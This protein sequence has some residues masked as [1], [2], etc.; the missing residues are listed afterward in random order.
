MRLDGVEARI[1]SA[2]KTVA[3]CFRLRN[4]LGLDVAIEALDLC[5][6]RKG[7]TPATLPKAARICRVDK[8]MLPDL[9]GRR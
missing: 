2:E 8:V 6:R 9:Q 5:I 7:A 4:K 3:D 1:Y